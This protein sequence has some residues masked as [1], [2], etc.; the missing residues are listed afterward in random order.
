MAGKVV[1]QLA[2][3]G[4]GQSLMDRVTAAKHSLAGSGLAKAVCK[5]TTE[6]ITAPKK[7]HLQY[8]I[9]C[10][11]ESNVSIPELANELLDRLKHPNWVVVF[12]S[13]ITLH[14]LMNHGNERFAQYLASNNCA[15]SSPNY[16]DRTTPQAAEMSRFIVRYSAY[17][18]EK[19]TA[20]RLMA[21]DFCK[22][23]RGTDDSLLRTLTVEK[24]IKSLEVLIN[25][26]D[27]L[28]AFEVTPK[29]VTNGVISAACL[30]L[31][32]DATRLFVVF[33]DGIINL[34]TKFF[35]TT[36]KKQCREALEIYK[37]FLV[38]S[39]LLNEFNKVAECVG[40]DK[41]DITRLQ[42]HPVSFL[43]AMETHL[44]QL[45]GR[46][47]EPPPREPEPPV[48]EAPPAA[49]AASRQ[50]PARPASSPADGPPAGPPPPRPPGPSRPPKPEPPK[51]GAAGGGSQQ[52]Q[53][54]QQSPPQSEPV[55]EAAAAPAVQQPAGGNDI[56]AE[57]MVSQTAASNNAAQQ[58][59]Q[60][61]P[62]AAGGKVN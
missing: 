27:S 45:E 52:Q 8:L 59:Q 61:K 19:A 55:A 42:K 9:E 13:L 29:D 4:S 31:Y 7:K 28:L 50:P 46:T 54:Q 34:L 3:S 14:N 44:A 58:Q 18:Q 36:S 10:T 41:S 53:Q 30:I 6:E 48:Q 39:D 60:Q 32:R 24:S 62:A 40:V 49:A 57:F 15:I 51:I 33:N 25:Q 43:D 22:V 47:Y 35:S 1:K 11:N 2:G 21:F 20:Y 56:L 23:K 5:A 12:K 26:F 16:S 17:I 38:R 37:K